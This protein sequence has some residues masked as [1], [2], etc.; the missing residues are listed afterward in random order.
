MTAL[1]HAVRMIQEPLRGDTRLPS[2]DI[3][4]FDRIQRARILLGIELNLPIT[5]CAMSL[6]IAKDSFLHRQDCCAYGLL[7]LSHG[8]TLICF[9]ATCLHC[10]AVFVVIPVAGL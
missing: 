8:L 5:W 10:S 4:P 2:V 7:V 3:G 1:Q 6:N 9:L